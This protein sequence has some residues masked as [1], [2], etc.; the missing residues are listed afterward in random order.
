[1]QAR[2][3]GNDSYEAV[4]QSNAAKVDII[5][6]QTIVIITIL[7]YIM[8]AGVLTGVQKRKRA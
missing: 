1:M 6:V 7:Y 4:V 5:F 8:Y 3:S 2:F